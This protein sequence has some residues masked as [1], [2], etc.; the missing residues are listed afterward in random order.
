MGRMNVVL[1]RWIRYF[2][3]IQCVECG[4]AQ[5]EVLC[6]VCQTTM[7]ETSAVSLSLEGID[8]VAAL[9]RYSGSIKALI[10]HIKFGPSREGAAL[11]AA[12][13]HRRGSV[14]PLGDYDWIIPIPGSTARERLRG[15]CL[16]DLIFRP[17][18]VT[19]GGRMSPILRRI[20]ETRPLFELGASE[21]KAEVAGIF[22]VSPQFVSLGES[23][24]LVDDIVTSGATAQ[25]AADTLRRAGAGRVD[26]LT[27]AAA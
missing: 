22:S 21:R 26:L 5:F 13:A 1:K 8:R 2:L 25:S 23:V 17:M 18:V 19:A 15:F 20:R 7:L 14:L 16:P 3:P 27:V 9:F 4:D 10:H 6:A 24:L 11:L 12:V